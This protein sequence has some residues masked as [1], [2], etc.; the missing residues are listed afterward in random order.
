MAFMSDKEKL[1]E[2]ALKLSPADKADMVHKLIES[3]D[4]PDKEIDDLW[5]TEAESRIDAYENDKLKSIS[6]E[7]ALS[8]YKT[9]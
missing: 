5:M 9:Q 4:L 8:K 6:V 1:V 7:E 3:L 2:Q